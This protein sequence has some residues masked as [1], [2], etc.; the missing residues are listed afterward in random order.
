M[1]KIYKVNNKAFK[2]QLYFDYYK[3]STDFQRNKKCKNYYIQLDQ[4]KNYKKTKNR[5]K[6]NKKMLQN[7]S[8]KIPYV[9][10]KQN[11]AKSYKFN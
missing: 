5:L 2:I 8:D 10:V 1:S 4:L 7:R 9:Q 11:T 3:S 6:R